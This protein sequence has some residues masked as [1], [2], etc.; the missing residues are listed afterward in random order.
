MT[1]RSLL[2]PATALL[3]LGGALTLGGCAAVDGLVHKQSTQ[4][5]DDS[6][7]FRAEAP[8]KA[9]WVPD[10]ATA[11]TVRTST[12][13]EAADA[14][15]LLRSASASLPAE[16]VET[17]RTSAPSWTLDDAPSA[18]DAKT[19]FVCGD[20]SVIPASGGWYGWTPN[21]DD[22]RNAAQG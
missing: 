17:S 2:L 12:M 21:S 14:V 10:D 18:Y 11:I 5:F 15:I 3:L 13:K 6:A 20:W 22:E 4:T 16:C 1:R 7:A 8:V 19:V 9:D